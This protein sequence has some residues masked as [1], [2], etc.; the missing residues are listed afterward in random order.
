MEITFDSL[1]ELYERIKPALAVKKAQM[2]REGYTYIKE[3]DIWNYFKE[4]KWHHA[5]NLFLHD[6]VSDVINAESEDINHYVQNKM[7]KQRRTAKFDQ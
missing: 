6:L 4:I 7:Q 3:A 2:H 5:Q 1:Q